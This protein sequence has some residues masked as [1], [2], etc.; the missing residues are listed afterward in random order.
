MTEEDTYKK[1]Y[2][3]EYQARLLAE[4]L[5]DEKT[6]EVF[7]SMLCLQSSNAQLLTQKNE[8]EMLVTIANLTQQNFIFRDELQHYLT[9]ACTLLQSPYGIV[10]LLSDDE[11]NAFP[12]DII[13]PNYDDHPD[14]F[15]VLIE[16]PGHFDGSC[17]PS[18]FIYNQH[19]YLWSNEQYK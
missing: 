3:R 7:Q 2:E 4:K 11:R 17:L 15:S 5:L 1:A 8:L 10:Y 9:T 14:L 16:E 18:Q 6:R 13:Y 19:A 12:G